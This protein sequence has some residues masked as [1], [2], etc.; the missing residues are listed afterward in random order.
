M[1]NDD[2]F[3]EQT[4]PNFSS[5]RFFESPRDYRQKQETTSLIFRFISPPF[6]ANFANSL[7]TQSCLSEK[8][9]QPNFPFQI[10]RRALFPGCTDLEIS[11]RAGRGCL[12]FF[13]LQQTGR[14]ENRDHFPAA[15]LPPVLFVHHA[16]LTNS[17]SNANASL[18]L[19]LCSLLFNHENNLPLSLSLFFSPLSIAIEKPRAP[20]LSFLSKK[21][22]DSRTCSFMEYSQERECFALI[23]NRMELVSII[24]LESRVYFRSTL[25]Y[26][27][28]FNNNIQLD[29]LSR[30]LL[31]VISS[32][33]FRE[34][35]LVA[36]FLQSGIR[37][38]CRAK[39]Q[40]SIAKRPL[41]IIPPEKKMIH[42]E[43]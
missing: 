18:S 42:E 23:K 12:H 21:R 30:H 34:I 11:L 39:F 4:I 41:M 37:E 13:P 17:N 16:Q 8:P 6:F 7:T 22:M 10:R 28:N 29:V 25:R 31:R 35:C 3:D 24:D 26:H 5:T 32:T 1:T 9:F 19:L 27:P 14:E 20:L 15:P 33:I 40:S 36:S 38:K 2:P 43:E